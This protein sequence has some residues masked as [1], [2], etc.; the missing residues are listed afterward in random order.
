LRKFRAVRAA[1]SNDTL[2]HLVP[3]SRKIP[4]YVLTNFDKPIT[5]IVIPYLDMESPS[6][7]YSL[8][9]FLQE[10]TADMSGPPMTDG[11]AYDVR[12]YMEAVACYGG[13]SK[14]G[15]TT[16]GLLFAVDDRGKAQ[17][18]FIKDVRELALTPKL[19]FEQRTMA[20]REAG[21]ARNLHE[22]PSL[23]VGL[24][25]AEQHVPTHRRGL[26]R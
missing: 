16:G 13:S 11:E 20:V 22:R 3:L 14:I 19:V 18:L 25:E 26:S 2:K 17:Y 15:T 21:L 1:V 12:Q 4:R 8:E 10:L 6:G 9:Q 7:D 24:R 5:S 23:E